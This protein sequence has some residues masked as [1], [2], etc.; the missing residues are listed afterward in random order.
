MGRFPQSVKRSSSLGSSMDSR[1]V[2]YNS[3]LILGIKDH[4]CSCTV[5]PVAAYMLITQCIVDVLWY[6]QAGIK[7]DQ[8]P[9]GGAVLLS[10]VRL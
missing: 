9:Q 2:G 1:V 5:R 8:S 7:H 10:Q 4:I 3:G 6:L